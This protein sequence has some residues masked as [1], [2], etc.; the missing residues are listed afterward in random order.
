MVQL[1]LFITKDSKKHIP[2]QPSCKKSLKIIKPLQLIFSAFLK[3]LVKDKLIEVKNLFT[4]SA[5]CQMLTIGMPP[6]ASMASQLLSNNNLITIWVRLLNLTA[7]TL[8]ERK[9]I[10]IDHSVYQLSGR[11]FLTKISNQ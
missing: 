8:S 3:T 6:D 5:I 1:P 4:E 7:E 9:R 10:N 11:I 2:R